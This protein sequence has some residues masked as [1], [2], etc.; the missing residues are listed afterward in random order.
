[1]LGAFL[2]SNRTAAGI[3]ADVAD[4]IVRLRERVAA[5]EGRRPW[6]PAKKGGRR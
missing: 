6:R 3:L 2:A 1:M 5:L 4:E